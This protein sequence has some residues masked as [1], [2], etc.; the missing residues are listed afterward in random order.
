MACVAAG[1]QVLISG[2]GNSACCGGGKKEVYVRS[3]CP[4][5]QSSKTLGVACKERKILKSIFCCTDEVTSGGHLGRGG[6]L[7]RGLI[8]RSESWNFESYIPLPHI[9]G[10]E[11]G[12]RLSPITTGQ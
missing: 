12:W 3:L 8:M 7:P 10:G 9:L 5:W 11:G 1:A 6:W 2:P 4:S